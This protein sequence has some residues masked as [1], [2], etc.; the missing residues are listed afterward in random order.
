MSTRDQVG[1]KVRHSTSAN[2]E[3]RSKRARSP[4]SSRAG[5]SLMRSHSAAACESIL[6]LARSASTRRDA[7]RRFVS[8]NVVMSLPESR[9]AWSMRAR[10]STVARTSI[11]WFRFRVAVDMIGSLC[12]AIVRPRVGH[13][14]GWSG[15]RT[16]SRYLHKIRPRALFR[17]GGGRS[18]RFTTDMR[19]RDVE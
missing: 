4:R 2:G 14:K 13:V 8:T 1:R 5:R 15:V 11:R 7:S 16:K 19:L 18:L 10:S 17:H 6:K 12:T 9:T 3:G